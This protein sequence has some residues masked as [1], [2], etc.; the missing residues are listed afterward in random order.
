[1]MELRNVKLCLGNLQGI[2]H[3]GDKGI[4][5]IILWHVDSSLGNDR[6]TKTRQRPLLGNGP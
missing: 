4:D 3:F 6:E 1:M 2:D 5:S